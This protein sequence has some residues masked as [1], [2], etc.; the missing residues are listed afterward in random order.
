MSNKEKETKNLNPK[1]ENIVHSE[2]V[3][4]QPT[5]EPDEP[6][7]KE[8]SKKHKLGQDLTDPTDKEDAGGRTPPPA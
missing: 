8:E 3:D 6:E 2:G 5:I 7:K 4:G 1:N